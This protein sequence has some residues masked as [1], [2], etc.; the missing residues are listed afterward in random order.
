VLQSG[1]GRLGVTIRSATSP[2]TD[3]N[4]LSD[5]QI[6]TMTNAVI[7]VPNGVQGAVGTL[8]I[9]VQVGTQETQFTLRRTAP[10]PFKADLVITDACGPWRTFVGAGV[11]V[12]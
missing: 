7:D 12:P 5:V 4:A 10:G 3:V 6:T 9:P 1:P 11:G 8:S 2:T